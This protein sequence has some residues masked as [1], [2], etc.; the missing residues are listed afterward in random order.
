MKIVILVFIGKSTAMD[1]SGK[2]GNYQESYKDSGREYT[3]YTGNVPPSI[4]DKMIENSCEPIR[5]YYKDFFGRGA[6]FV[7]DRRN[8]VIFFCETVDENLKVSS[9]KAVIKH[10]GFTSCS[11]EIVIENKPEFIALEKQK[12]KLSLR[13][14]FPKLPTNEM[15][16]VV[17]VNSSIYIGQSGNIETYYCFNGVWY[18]TADS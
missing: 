11:N 8:G 9:Y 15:S 16:K 4:Y 6:P 5:D 2:K 18:M 7:D 12:L 14:V 1:N 13:D 10:Q 3:K 17:E